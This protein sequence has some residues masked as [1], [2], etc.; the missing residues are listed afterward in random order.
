M[1]N[2][3]TLNEIGHLNSSG[4]GRPWPRHGLYLLH[5]FSHNYV[6]FD[7]NGDLRAQYNPQE[8]LFG[9]HHFDNRLECDGN[10]YQL[11]P[12]Q[13]IP[14]YEVGNLNKPGAGDL[15]LYV[16]QNYKK[17]HDDNNMD[18]IIIS[19]HPDLV[20]DKVYVTQH[21]DVRTFDRQNTYRISRGL[22]RLIR[23][24]ELEEL[25][26]QAG[27]HRTIMFVK[28]VKRQETPAR[29]HTTVCQPAV[30]QPDWVNIKRPS[31]VSPRP[32]PS[33][34]SVIDMPHDSMPRGNK[35]NHV[36]VSIPES[37]DSHMPRRERQ[38]CAIL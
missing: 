37:R 1:A 31:A 16:R 34:E 26:K 6:I 25:L 14:Y 24:L 35:I 27:Y 4:F 7:N 38:C 12:N 29:S 9:F 22:V 18:R 32:T 2:I 15:P 33:R 36:S 11:L 3:K 23:N 30:S 28:A 8:E 19:L 10:R 17:H 13:N 5:W 21:K 20:L